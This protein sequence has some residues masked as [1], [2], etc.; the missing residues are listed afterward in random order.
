MQLNVAIRQKDFIPVTDFKIQLK[1]K[2]IL[3]FDCQR[4]DCRQIFLLDTH[5]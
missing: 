4:F 1:W 2:L 5:I 3:L